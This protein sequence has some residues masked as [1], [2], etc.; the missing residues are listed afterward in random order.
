MNHL[1]LSFALAALAACG[2]AAPAVT[3]PAAAAKAKAAPPAATALTI[4]ELKFYQGNELGMVLHP[5]GK[6]EVKA[7]HAAGTKPV[8]ETWTE[9]GRLTPEGKLSH[10]DKVGQ[11]LPDGSFQTSDG[12]LAPWKLVGEALEIESRQITIDDKGM[13]HGTNEGFDIHVTGITDGGSKRTAL[14]LVALL[15]G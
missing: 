14:L 11:L 13:F 10:E 2:G 6:L 12:Q 15:S 4:T 5:D 7:K 8:E 1:A 3:Q 9:V